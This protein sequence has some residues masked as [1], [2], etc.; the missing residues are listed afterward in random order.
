[1]SHSR[2][3]LDVHKVLEATTER[4]YERLSA[5]GLTATTE[6]FLTGIRGRWVTEDEHGFQFCYIFDS[7]AGDIFRGTDD[8]I[9]L[10]VTAR[11]RRYTGEPIETAFTFDYAPTAD[12][13]TFIWGQTHELPGASTPSSPIQIRLGPAG[14]SEFLVL[15]RRSYDYYYAGKILASSYLTIDRI[16]NLN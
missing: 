15:C 7:F 5:S 12:T 10:A 3:S 14:A 4:M 1:M 8:S 6:T 16:F 2:Q 9:V 13:L 11:G